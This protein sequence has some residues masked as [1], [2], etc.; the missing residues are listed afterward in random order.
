M[1]R[2]IDAYL[3]LMDRDVFCPLPSQYIGG[4]AR[5]GQSLRIP[6]SSPVACVAGIWKKGEMFLPHRA[7]I[8]SAMQDGPPA[9]D[10][11]R[12]VHPEI[13]GGIEERVNCVPGPGRPRRIGVCEYPARQVRQTA[14]HGVVTEQSPH[15]R[16]RRAGQ[17]L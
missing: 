11:L 15:C 1:G 4:L 9:R 16:V 2:S 17:A 10:V 8:L 3:D 13:Y 6:E 14:A 5:R 7:R 12:F